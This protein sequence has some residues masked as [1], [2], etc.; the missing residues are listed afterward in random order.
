MKV[1]L[2]TLFSGILLGNGWMVKRIH[3]DDLHVDRSYQRELTS[4]IHNIAGDNFREESLGL[5]EVGQRKGTGKFYVTDGQ[6]RLE[7]VRRRLSNGDPAPRTLLCLVKLNTTRKEEAQMFVEKNMNRPVT[8]NFRFKGRM[9]WGQAPETTI[10]QWA[11]ES[12]FVLQYRSPGGVADSD[13]DGNGIYSPAVLLQVYNRHADGLKK[14]FEF[15]RALYKQANY[16]PWA[17]RSGAV[18]AGLAIFFS[19]ATDKDPERAARQFKLRSY[20][21]V[22]AIEDCRKDDG[23]NR[24][25]RRFAKLVSEWLM[26]SLGNGIVGVFNKKAG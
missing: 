10:A 21:L 5:L 11:K 7:A 9:V 1:S 16:V 12:G 15:L 19:H 4:N 18:I 23:N 17:A 2:T 14:A 3:V 8:G 20:D 24:N 22:A 26:R 13:K 6:T 25:K